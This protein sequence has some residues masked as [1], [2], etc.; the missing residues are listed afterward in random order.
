MGKKKVKKVKSLNGFGFAKIRHLQFVIII[1]LKVPKITSST[2]YEDKR[3]HKQTNTNL[4]YI[5]LYNV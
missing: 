5:K 1:N 4:G 2:Y 3:L